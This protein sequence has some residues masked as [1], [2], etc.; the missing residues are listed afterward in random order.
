[1]NGVSRFDTGEADP[2]YVMYDPL[3]QGGQANQNDLKLYNAMEY[4]TDDERSMYNYLY[5]QVS[6]KDADDYV[7]KYLLPAIS[8][9]NRYASFQ[10]RSKMADADLEEQYKIMNGTSRFD[11]GEADPEYVLYDPLSQGGQVDSRNLELYDKMEYVTDYE[12]DTYNKLYS[13]DKEAAAE[14]V[15]TK[16]MPAINKRKQDEL[17]QTGANMINPEDGESNGW[18]TVG[19]NLMSVPLNLM[20]GI[21]S[22]DAAAQML[23]NKI[24]GVDDPV[25]FNSDAFGAYNL[26]A[27]IRETTEE[28]IDSAAGRFFYGTGMSML[29]SLATQALYMFPGATLLLG[30]SAATEA[31]IQGKKRGLSDEQAVIFGLSSGVAEAL[32]EE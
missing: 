29:D 28:G 21:G 10:E 25:D 18:R 14:Y 11:T 23:A 6:E 20:S 19:A 26:K 4:V 9:R 7:N 3:S 22:V 31:M 2:N 17:Y 5:N 27:G 16:L 1:M 12:R 8:K 32:F 15:R 13:E 24:N 30:G